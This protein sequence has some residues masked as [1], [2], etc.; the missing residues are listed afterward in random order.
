[1]TRCHACARVHGQRRWIKPSQADSNYKRNAIHLGALGRPTR[2]KIWHRAI[3]L[4]A[5]ARW[6]K[7]VGPV[8]N[9][10]G[11]KSPGARRVSGNVG[12]TFAILSRFSRCEIFLLYEFGCRATSLS[13]M[14]YESR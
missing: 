9:G 7:R 6:A 5:C 13:T 4:S 1:M 3:Q 12:R 14:N 10:D 2:H 8:G 11:P